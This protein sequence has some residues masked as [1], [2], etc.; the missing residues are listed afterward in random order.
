MARHGSIAEQLAPL[1]RYATTPDHDPEPIQTNW[2]TVAAN[3]N[4]PEDVAEMAQDRKRL[5]TP[6]IAEIMRNVATGD[7]ERND[8]GQVIRIGRLRF[9]DGTQTERCIMSGIDGKPITGDIT[10]PA[11]A[12]LG[13]RDN[14]EAALGDSGKSKSYVDLSNWWH[15]MT[16][17]ISLPHRF[18]PAGKMRR[19]DRA[20][21]REDAAEDLAKAIANTPIMP[22]VKR[23][24]DG[25]PCGMK[26][27]ADAFVGMRK[28][29][30]G[31]T[32]SMAWQ[33]FA[34]LKSARSAWRDVVQSL[35]PENKATLDAALTAKNMAELG[36]CA[37]KRTAIRRGK[38]RLIA[39]N[40]DLMHAIESFA[41]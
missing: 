27:V 22:E 34:T 39:A 40:N 20:V 10:M 35:D 13:A 4:N 16:L 41:A 19:T 17:G 31:E 3:D 38:A 21:S 7:V 36:G 24:P 5:V 23:Y 9:S 18:I 29:R 37:P 32:G 15:Q 30:K 2:A 1:L 12:M 28:G 26:Q 11:G 33:D 8:K 6:S 25:L 14:V